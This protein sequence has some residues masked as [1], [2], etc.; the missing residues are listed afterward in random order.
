[1]STRSAARSPL[2][3]Q[4]EDEAKQLFP[5]AAAAGRVAAMHSLAD[6][7]IYRDGAKEATQA[8][9]A[10]CRATRADAERP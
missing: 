1:V 7:L 5:R 2:T 8:E 9:A 10:A 3:D 4:R 6:L